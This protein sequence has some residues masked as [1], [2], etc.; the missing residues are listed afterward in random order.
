MPNN[1]EVK[2]IIKDIAQK[3]FLNSD[4]LQKLSSFNEESEKYNIAA[5]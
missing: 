2:Q 3:Y 5:N 1:L 4:K